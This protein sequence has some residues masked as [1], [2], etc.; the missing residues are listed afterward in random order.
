MDMAAL[1][2][3]LLASDFWPSIFTH[4][5]HY[6]HRDAVPSAVKTVFSA[7]RRT[8]SS[9]SVSSSSRARFYCTKLWD[10]AIK[11]QCLSFKVTRVQTNQ[12]AP[13]CHFHSAQK[14]TPSSLSPS[15]L[16][17]SLHDPRS[18]SGFRGSCLHRP[19]ASSIYSL[20]CRVSMVFQPA[21]SGP[22]SHLQLVCPRPTHPH[23]N[24]DSIVGAID[25]SSRGP[26]TIASPYCTSSS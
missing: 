24:L 9:T 11:F 6:T 3:W 16:A 21:F 13:Y 4:T 25:S 15:A 22:L 5:L 7:G 1:H 18:G 10:L 14:G 12:H 20:A 17:A 23:F 26:A 8:P 19:T 2:H